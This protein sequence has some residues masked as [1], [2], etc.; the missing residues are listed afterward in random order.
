M[1]SHRIHKKNLIVSY[2]N[3]SDELKALFAETYPEGYKDHLQRT[4]KPN[5]EPIFVV[6]L[7]TDD[8]VYMIKF[9]VKIDTAL[10]D[11]DLDKDLYD[12]SMDKDDE[13]S[14]ISEAL[15]KDEDVNNHTERVLKHGA[16][17]EDID[18]DNHKKSKKIAVD[19]ELAAAFAAAEDDFDD[20]DDEDDEEEEDG[21]DFEPTDED[22]KDIEDEYLDAEI[23]PLDATIP[24][25][26]EA[27]K[28][29]TKAKSADKQAS[30]RKKSKK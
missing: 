10:A 16:Y 19:P 13:F 14:P 21:D 25:E 7:E 11:D 2:K 1:N 28:R 3:L 8:T 5:G 26:A 15:E 29:S 27:P 9:E 20:F 17:E 18:E 6:P 12:D 30:P 22:L 4:I 24:E 23:P